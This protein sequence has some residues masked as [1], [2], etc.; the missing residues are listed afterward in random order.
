MKRLRNY[1][2][3]AFDIYMGAAG[4]SGHTKIFSVKKAIICLVALGFVLLIEYA[5]F[6]IGTNNYFYDLS[7]RIR[8][9]IPPSKDVVIIAI[10]DKS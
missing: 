5:G 7:F 2:H 8:G 9:S 10:D 4:Q 1:Y 6:F 3:K